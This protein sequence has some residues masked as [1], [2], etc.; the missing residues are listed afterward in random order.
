LGVAFRQLPAQAAELSDGDI[1][2]IK[3]ARARKEPQRQA[4]RLPAD[5]R[6]DFDLVE[7]SL[8]EDAARAE[9]ARCFQCSTL[10]DKCVEVCP[11]RANYTYFVQPLSLRVPVLVCHDDVLTP[12]G[13]QHFEVVQARQI[14]HVD[15][16]CN[17]CGNCAT[18]CVH[19]GKPYADKPRLFLDEADFRQETDNAFHITGDTIRHREGGRESA[20]T[21]TDDGM[22][23][24]DAHVQVMLSSEFAILRMELKEAFEGELSLV[25]AAEMAMIFTGILRSLPF[26]T[27]VNRV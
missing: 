6:D 21:F 27:H 17:E 20:L 14:L 3:H 16:F 1:L 8:T 22:V 12:T 26:L 24:E 25:A 10:C 13:D 4:E 5:Q 18:F 2:N 19:Q 7:Q 15:D 11:N 9:A 23:Y